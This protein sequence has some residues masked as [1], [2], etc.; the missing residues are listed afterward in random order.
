MI[1]DRLDSFLINLITRKCALVD[2]PYGAFN[3]RARQAIS[4][5][6]LRTWLASSWVAR[7]ISRDAV[8][9]ATRRNG[10]AL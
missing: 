2:V 5:A 10:E 3:A 9:A 7:R 1:S 4:E 8:V 6:T